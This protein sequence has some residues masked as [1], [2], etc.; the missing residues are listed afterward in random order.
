MSAFAVQ[1]IG[2]KDCGVTKRETTPYAFVGGYSAVWAEI[3]G[4]RRFSSVDAASL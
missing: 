1:D 3:G 4:W 2:Q